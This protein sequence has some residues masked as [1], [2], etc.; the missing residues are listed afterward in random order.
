MPKIREVII[1]CMAVILKVRR[2]PEQDVEVILERAI[3]EDN[4]REPND[5]AIEQYER[6]IAR[7]NPVTDNQ[8]LVTFVTSSAAAT[9]GASVA[10]AI[11][12]WVGSRNGRRYRIRHGDREYEAPSLKEMKKLIKLA[13]D[14]LRIRILPPS[15]KDR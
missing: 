9:F 12:H 6:H 2:I 1:P 5:V 3:G 10:Q 15:G 14:E 4:R 7:R 11:S 13:G 8:W